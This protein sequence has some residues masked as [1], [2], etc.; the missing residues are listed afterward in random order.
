MKTKE[1]LPVTEYQDFMRKLKS[2]LRAV[3]IL[4]ERFFEIEEVCSSSLREGVTVVNFRGDLVSIVDKYLG[5]LQLQVYDHLAEVVNELE[6][7]IDK[8]RSCLIYNNE[9]EGHE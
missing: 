5:G 6:L 2:Q 1:K 9:D 3:Q 8:N 4:S 7:M